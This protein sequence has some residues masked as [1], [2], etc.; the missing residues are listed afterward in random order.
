MNIFRSS[1]FSSNP[2]RSS[3]NRLCRRSDT[4]L[5][6]Y[7]DIFYLIGNEHLITIQLNLITLQFYIRLDAWEVEDTGQIERIVDIEV[8]PEQRFVLH[9][10]ESLIEFLIILILQCARGLCPQRFYIINNVIFV[11]FLLFTV[12]PFRLFSADD[13]NRHKLA[14]LVEQAFNLVLVKEFLAVVIYI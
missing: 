8:N 2:L 1:H 10:V 6:I 9:R 7:D 5:V 12:F 4:F 11:C 14:I 3:L 13:R